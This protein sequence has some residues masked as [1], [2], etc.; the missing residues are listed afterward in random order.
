MSLIN[1]DAINNY[2]R[3][4]EEFIFQNFSLISLLTGLLLLINNTLFIKK[5]I[6]KKKNIEKNKRYYALN[7][8]GIVLLC[9]FLISHCVSPYLPSSYKNLKAKI[10]APV[11]PITVSPLRSTPTPVIKRTPSPS[12]S[13]SPPKPAP[14]P[15]RSPSPPKPAP[16]L[17]S[18]SKKFNLFE[19]LKSKTSSEPSPKPRLPSP[20]KPAPT[21]TRSPSPPKPAPA[22]SSEP[23]KFNLFEWLKSKPSS[24]P[25]P[26]PRLPSP[27]RPNADSIGIETPR[28]T[29][30]PRELIE[31]IETDGSE[32]EGLRIAA[33]ENP[34]IKRQLQLARSIQPRQPVQPVSKL[35]LLTNGEFSQVNPLVRPPLLENSLPAPPLVQPK[36]P[37]GPQIVEPVVSAPPKG[38]HYGYDLGLGRGR[39]ADVPQ[40]PKKK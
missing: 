33:R 1:I 38:P 13:P 11:K 3:A 9:I 10:R 26:K 34:N 27:P 24:E 5:D 25:S 29:I 23:K 28:P 37:S 40:L 30:P 21:P 22:L 19:W 15:T 39:S 31:E 17:S 32:N 12:R 14:T 35:L 18:E 16:A 20:P 8:T 7:I 2:I 36:V 4:F 6:D